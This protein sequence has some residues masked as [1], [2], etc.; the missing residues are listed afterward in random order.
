MKECEYLSACPFFA[1][2]LPEMPAMAQ[3]LKS[4]YCQRDSDQCARYI[5]RQALGKE[6]VP[7][8]LFPDEAARAAEIIAKFQ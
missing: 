8:N 4:V 1:D 5:V 3:Y 6:K 7:L 2:T